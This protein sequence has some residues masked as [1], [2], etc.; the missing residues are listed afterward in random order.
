[1]LSTLETEKPG[2]STPPLGIRFMPTPASIN[3]E[4]QETEEPPATTWEEMRAALET[5][6]RSSLGCH[7]FEKHSTDLTSES[8]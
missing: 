3:R 5:P 7:H 2:R 4:A 1:V 6:R 8:L